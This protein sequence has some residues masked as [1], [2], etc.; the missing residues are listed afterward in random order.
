MKKI[1]GFI[2][3]IGIFAT[4]Q[5]SN[6][7]STDQTQSL[8]DVGKL[9]SKEEAQRWTARYDKASFGARKQSATTIS[10]A[11]LQEVVGAI[12]EYDGVYFQHALE[13]DNHHVLVIP[14]KDGQ[15]LWATT[16]VVDAN[17]D[18][19][20][21]V[22]TASLWADEYISE[23]PEGPWS[24]FFG[25]H[26][27]ETILSNEAFSDVEIAPAINDAGLP[28]LLLYV[29]YVNELSNGRTEAQVDVYDQSHQC[30]PF[31]PGVQ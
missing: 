6:K 22:G 7:L 24:H 31:C 23:N 2:L 26:V 19:K 20:I 29:S 17:Q 1:I 15:S 5:D 16:I 13:G 3:L 8:R 11:S 14:Y 27:F 30:P 9:I 25:R 28:Q 4:C 18:S 12:S 10:K 21:E